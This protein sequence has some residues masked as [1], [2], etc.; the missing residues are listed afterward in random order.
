MNPTWAP[1]GRIYFNSD[2]TKAWQIYAVLPNGTN[3]AA[4]TAT[5]TP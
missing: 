2:R 1:D 4:I 3:L 5:S